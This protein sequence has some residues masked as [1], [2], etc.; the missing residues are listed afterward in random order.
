MACPALQ[1]AAV[2]RLP[3]LRPQ[4]PYAIT[5]QGFNLRDRQFNVTVGAGAAGPLVW[6]HEAGCFTGWTAT[7]RCAMATA[8]AGVGLPAGQALSNTQEWQSQPMQSLTQC[9]AASHNMCSRRWP[10]MSC[11][12]WAP[13]IPGSADSRVRG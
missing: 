9:G 10:G 4:Y 6:Q 7:D 12:A 8:Y 11:R 13:C 1:S 2:V 3:T 5:D